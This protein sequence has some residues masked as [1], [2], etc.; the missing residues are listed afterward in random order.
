MTILCP[1]HLNGEKRCILEGADNGW[2]YDGWG[3]MTLHA[4]NSW[5]DIEFVTTGTSLYYQV[6]YLYLRV[7]F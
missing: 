3:P 4:V 2:D 6:C 5:Q 7:V 1:E